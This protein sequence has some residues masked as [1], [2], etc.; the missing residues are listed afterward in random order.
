MIHLL[1][2]TI[3]LFNFL[4]L[5]I[6]TALLACWIILFISKAGI[7]EY[8]QVNAP[9]KLS[10]L[11]ECDFCL[12]WWICLFIAI[13]AMIFFDDWRLIFIAYCAAPITRYLL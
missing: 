1:S 8:I 3:I 11:F 13:C 4:I 2:T 7:R 10:E 12:S 5:T 6:I 9:K